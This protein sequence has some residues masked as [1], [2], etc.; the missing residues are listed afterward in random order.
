MIDKFDNICKACYKL[1]RI[2]EIILLMLRLRKKYNHS[3][4][5]QSNSI[6]IRV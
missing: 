5:E 4:E 1:E 2:T 3:K 6:I